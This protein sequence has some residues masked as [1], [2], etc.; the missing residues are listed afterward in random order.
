V[1]VSSPYIWRNQGFVYGKAKPGRSP[2]LGGPF[3]LFVWLGA[4]LMFLTKNSPITFPRTVVQWHKKQFW[5]H[6]V[7]DTNSCSSDV[8]P[9][10]RFLVFLRDTIESFD[11]NWIPS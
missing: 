9:G 5:C 1:L 3:Q 4:F 11:S 6:Q 7:V 2:P 8:E 10:V